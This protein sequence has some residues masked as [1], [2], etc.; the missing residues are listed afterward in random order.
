MRQGFYYG[1]HVLA[2]ISGLLVLS[3]TEE[4]F[5][6]SPQILTVCSSALVMGG[7]LLAGKLRED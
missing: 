6:V 2:Y 7:E 4:L 5:G 1:R 3:L